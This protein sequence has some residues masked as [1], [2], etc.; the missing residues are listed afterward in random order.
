MVIQSTSQTQNTTEPRGLRD[1]ESVI[2]AQSGKAAWGRRH[3]NRE[4]SGIWMG[5]FQKVRASQA[6]GTAQGKAQRRGGRDSDK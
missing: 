4:K 6:E 1:R 5:K 2:W 3:L